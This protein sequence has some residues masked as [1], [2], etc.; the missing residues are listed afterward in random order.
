MKKIW[1][2]TLLLILLASCMDAVSIPDDKRDYVWIWQSNEMYL[3]IQ[4]DGY[5]DYKKKVW[6]KETSV[7]WPIAR[8]ENEDF[9]V[10][11]LGLE[12]KF[13]IQKVPYVKDNWKM[14]M[15]VDGITLEKQ[16]SN[17][18]LDDKVSFPSSSELDKLTMDT[19]TEFNKNI[20]AWSFDSFH[21]FISDAWNTQITVSELN[22]IFGN[23]ITN[24]D[25][26]LKSW[27]W[28]I[29]YSSQPY[30]D[31][32]NELVIEWS[33]SW[34]VVVNFVLNFINENWN[35]KI[36]GIEVNYDY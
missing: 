6:A 16:G 14:E 35:W 7:N 29:T 15:V 17:S 28:E 8:F 13:D 1:I 33:I 20:E 11:I 32:N 24:K 25:I 10:S 31:K 26:V 23:L 19:I 18:D 4:Q 36:L 34:D 30:L 9:V 22:G 27:K 12:T 3:N 2:F 5:I 21:D